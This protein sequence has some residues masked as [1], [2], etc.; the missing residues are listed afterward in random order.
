MSAVT[1]RSLATSF[2]GPHTVGHREQI[3]GSLPN[4]RATAASERLV[5]RMSTDL[6][7]VAMT[8]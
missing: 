8:K 1:A 5:W 4:L 3:S 6:R 2:G 7:T